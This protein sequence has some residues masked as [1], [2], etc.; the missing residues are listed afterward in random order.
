MDSPEN[1]PTHP[2]A[3]PG[4][5]PSRTAHL[6]PPWRKGQSGNP[7]GLTKD[8]ASTKDRPVRARLHAKLAK[9]RALDRMLDRWI[10]DAINAEDGSTRARAREQI[11]E[12]IDPVTKD[13]GTSKRPVVYEGLRIELPNGARA[14]IVRGQLEHLGLMP[15]TT[16]TRV[17]VHESQ[18][19]RGGV[20]DQRLSIPMISEDVGVPDSE[21][22]PTSLD[23][24]GGEEPGMSDPKDPV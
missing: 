1:T 23:S 17:V 10:D 3:T 15:P 7:S 6:R 9:R 16:D 18:E 12:R 14:E 22:S 11:L 24:V 20:A 21:E 13:D 19:S 4:A 5:K 8:G 2:T